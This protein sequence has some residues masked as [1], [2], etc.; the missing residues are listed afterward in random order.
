MNRRQFLGS[1]GATIAGAW[2]VP[3]SAQERCGQM[4]PFNY[5]AACEVGIIN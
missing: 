5:V 3:A 2:T 4:N 1:V